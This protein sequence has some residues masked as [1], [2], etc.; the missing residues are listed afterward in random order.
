MNPDRGVLDALVALWVALSVVGTIYQS[1]YFVQNAA[2][3]RRYIAR[4]TAI[5]RAQ[6]RDTVEWSLTVMDRAATRLNYIKALA[7][8]AMH[9]F[10]LVI[11]LLSALG[12]AA[13]QQNTEPRLFWVGV[14]FYSVSD[15]FVA[16]LVIVT[17]RSRGYVKEM[18]RAR[19]VSAAGAAGTAG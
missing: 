12:A 14:A 5:L 2:G 11:G 18:E 15:I 9:A 13:A 17:M 3:H 7:I 4:L 8:L 16:F 6:K 19:R 1:L 10:L